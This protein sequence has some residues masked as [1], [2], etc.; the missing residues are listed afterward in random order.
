MLMLFAVAGATAPL[1]ADL[2]TP[3]FLPELVVRDRLNSGNVLKT[4]IRL[5][6]MTDL[7]FE[8]EVGLRHGV[9]ERELKTGY[10]EVTHKIHAQAGGRVDLFGLV[11]LSA[12]AKVPVYTVASSDRWLAGSYS[13]PGERRHGYDLFER[14]DRISWTGEMG[15]H[16]GPADL[17]LFYDRN[18]LE[19]LAGSGEL[20]HFEETFGTRL[21]FRFK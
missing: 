17:N 6:P 14:P 9:W 20:S 11:S 7:V 3:V 4:G 8:P 18:R 2:D 13:Q 12:A 21:I 15:V 10:D 16:L 5:T 19:D 1:A